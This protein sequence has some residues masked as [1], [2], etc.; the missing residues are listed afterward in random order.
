MRR[1]NKRALEERIEVAGRIDDLLRK[2][3]FV[4]V[5]VIAESLPSDFPRDPIYAGI[6][7]ALDKIEG[8]EIKLEDHKTVDQLKRYFGGNCKYFEGE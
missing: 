7:A 3:N 2:G 6:V 8:Q 4:T 5:A 1:I